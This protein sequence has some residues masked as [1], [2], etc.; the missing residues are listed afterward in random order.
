MR[1]G[2]LRSYAPKGSPRRPLVVI[3]SS[4]GVNQS[5]RPWLLGA[6]VLPDDPGD[7]L[8]VPV[9][10]RGWASAGNLTRVYRPWLGDPVGELEPEVLEQ[11]SSALRAALD[12]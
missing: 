6:P 1:R 4:D 12:V 10:G 7:I 8:A 11:L 3:V 9:T 5:V 2:E